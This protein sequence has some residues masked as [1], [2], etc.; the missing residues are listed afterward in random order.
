[1]KNERSSGMFRPKNVQR[2]TYFQL[3]NVQIRL[4]FRLKNVREICFNPYLETTRVDEAT[5]RLFSGW[6][7]RA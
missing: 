7:M 3:K 5:K 4:A 2:N 1:M 6:M